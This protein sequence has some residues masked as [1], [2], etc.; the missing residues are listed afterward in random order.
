MATPTRYSVE[1][2]DEDLVY[3]SYDFTNRNAYNTAGHRL[4]SQSDIFANRRASQEDT[5]ALLGFLTE[6][7]SASALSKYDINKH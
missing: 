1:G 4:I 6:E 5:N 7:S 3:S 2:V